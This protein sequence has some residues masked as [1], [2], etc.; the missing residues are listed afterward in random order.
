M[1]EEQEAS[2]AGSFDEEAAAGVGVGGVESWSCH[3]GTVSCDH[4]E[5]SRDLARFIRLAG[6][7]GL[8]VVLRGGP[9]MCGEWEYGGFPAWLLQ[10]GTL[11]LRIRN[12]QI[13]SPMPPAPRTP[14]M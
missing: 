1:G 9:Y 14:K 4:R 3:R 13:L 11:A 8:F 10:N 2:R 5:E 7:H 6:A 12:V